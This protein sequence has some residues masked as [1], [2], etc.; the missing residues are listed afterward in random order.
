MKYEKKYTPIPDFDYSVFDD[1]EYKEDSVREDIIAPIIKALGY[2]SK[3]PYKI[4]RSR[5]LTHPFV[6][7]GSKRVGIHLIPDY[8]MEIDRKPAW[9]L[10][11]KSP[12]ES[13]YKSSHVEQAYSY[14]I[15][16]EIRAQYYALC[17][18]REF[19]M[20]SIN[21]YKPLYHFNIQ[22][23]P[24]YWGEL[25]SRLSPENYHDNIDKKLAKDYGLHLARL[26][27]GHFDSLF[28]YD[29]PV[30]F[31]QKINNDLYSISTGIREND[32]TYCLSFDFNHQT[33]L[34]LEDKIPRKAFEKLCTPLDSG[35]AMQF[36]F[37]DMRYSVTVKCH[38]G[39]IDYIQENEA[40]Q[41]LPLVVTDFI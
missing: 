36:E 29:L 14:S 38:L 13:I 41:F 11:A 28:Y 1:E 15:H 3:E 17:N 21:N 7:I 26:G 19:L 37:A 33:F 4:V 30:D 10:E 31:I 20:Y 18:G 39:D 32:E 9:I 5:K 25:Q 35:H 16:P 6:S 8:V 22:L 40:E 23:L 24:N 2:T 12:C 27:F 34:S